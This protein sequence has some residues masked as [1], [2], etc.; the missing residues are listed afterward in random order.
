MIALFVDP[1]YFCYFVCSLRG[2]RLAAWPALI[3]RLR[4]PGADFQVRI[5]ASSEA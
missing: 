5:F 3:V 1:D 2:S 4:R